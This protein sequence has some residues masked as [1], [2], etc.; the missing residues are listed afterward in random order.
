MAIVALVCWIITALGGF[1]LL[2]KWIAGGGT[3]AGTTSRLSPP[4]VFAHFLL[5]AAG[6]VLW[7]VYVAVEVDVLAWIAFALLVVIALA[8]FAM[9]ARWLPVYQGAAGT[10]TA[11]E[12][13]F[14]VAVVGAHG[15]VAVVTVV[16]VLLSAVGIG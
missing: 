10:E 5:A 2:G 14:P 15:A 1:V 4:I 3:T 6:L 8:G 11:P 13:G 9:F 16:S 7:I 12:K